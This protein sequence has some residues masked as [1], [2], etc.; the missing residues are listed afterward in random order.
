MKN[1]RALYLVNGAL[2]AGKTTLLQYLLQQEQYSGARVIENEFAAESVDSALVA[3][4][5]DEVATIA[6]SCICCSSS[7]ELTSLLRAFS[8]STAP[9]IIEST[10]VANSLKLIEQLI[11]AD[12]IKHYEL[13]Q[14]FYVLDALE[15]DVERVPEAMLR[16]AQAADI[17]LLSKIDRLPNKVARDLQALLR[18]RGLTNVVPMHFG[19]FDMTKLR[20][21][22]RALERAMLYGEDAQRADTSTYSVIDVA[23]VDIT[24]NLLEDVW[25]KLQCAYG[26]RRLKGD[27]HNKIQSW[28]IEATP[29][30]FRSNETDD[31]QNKIVIIGE[32][33]HEITH[34]I[35]FAE[36]QQ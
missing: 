32:R 3:R 29:H 22:S 25:R 8:S 16:E 18:D 6:G 21:P 17:V 2:G 36:M 13:K 30:Q 7:D 35:F 28:H 15:C 4:H 19:K 11:V 5:A 20:L 10:G 14:S 12:M 26:L 34:D 24:P 33:A 23:A 1:S 9:V 27:I 31:Q